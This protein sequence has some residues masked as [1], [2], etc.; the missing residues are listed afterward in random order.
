VGDVTDT[1]TVAMLSGFAGGL[2]ASEFRKGRE[3][4]FRTAQV[5]SVLGRV[6][7]PMHNLQFLLRVSY[8]AVVFSLSHEEYPYFF[9]GSRCKYARFG[10]FIAM[11]IQDVVFFVVTPCTELVGNQFGEVC[12]LHLQ[13]E[14]GGSMVFRNVGMLRRH[15]K[16][17]RDSNTF[18]CALVSCHGEVGGG[19]IAPRFPYLGARWK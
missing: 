2:D 12:C 4:V 18:P 19:G 7:K 13:G 1:A 15:N 9:K 16:E 10:V 17:D 6:Q 14:V 8:I 3:I 11:R 5:S